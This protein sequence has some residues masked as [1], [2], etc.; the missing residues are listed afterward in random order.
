[1]P[2]HIEPNDVA[3]CPQ[4]SK[5]YTITTEGSGYGGSKQ[6]ALDAARAQADEKSKLRPACPPG[7]SEERKV[8]EPAYDSTKPV[9]SKYGKGWKC[10]LDRQQK[11]L[12]ACKKKEDAG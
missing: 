10:T 1:M 8:E 4:E 6:A 9:Y 3:S 7:C 5:E 11:I 2:D 12:L